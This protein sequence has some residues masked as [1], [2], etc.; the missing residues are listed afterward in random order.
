MDQTNKLVT[1]ICNSIYMRERDRENRDG[2][3]I[4]IIT[5]LKLGTPNLVSGREQSTCAVSCVP[6]PD[7]IPIS[8]PLQ[9]TF[10]N[11]VLSSLFYILPYIYI[12]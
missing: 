6:F 3:Y 11:F 12:T 2:T 8:L 4:F 7:P 9:V 5:I 10:L 1:Y